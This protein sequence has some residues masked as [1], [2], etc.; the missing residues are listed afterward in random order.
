MMQPIV[1]HN[2]PGIQAWKNTTFHRHETA[3]PVSEQNTKGTTQVSEASTLLPSAKVTDML[4]PGETVRPCL[5]TSYA[6]IKLCIALLSSRVTIAVESCAKSKL[7]TH[8]TMETYSVTKVQLDWAQTLQHTKDTPAALALANTTN[9]Q[10]MQWWKH[11]WW[12]WL[13]RQL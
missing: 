12:I 9:M 5:E 8:P 4:W 10:T 13:A 3:C 7:H 1:T 2:Y 11:H 6:D